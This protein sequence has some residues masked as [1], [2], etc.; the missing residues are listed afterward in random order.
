MYI[1]GN[2]SSSQNLCTEI[3]KI[4]DI[5]GF[6][7]ITNGNCKLITESSVSDFTH[8]NSN[9][10]ILATNSLLKRLEFINYFNK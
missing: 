10:Y 1:L 6:I 9:K 8:E 7:T 2:D 4:F 3:N 5:Q